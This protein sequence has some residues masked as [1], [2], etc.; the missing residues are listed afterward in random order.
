VLLDPLAAAVVTALVPL[1]YI[2]HHENI[3]RLL[4]GT[5]S[6]IGAKAAATAGH[7]GGPPLGTV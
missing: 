3:A 6:K 7:N 4:D 2:R 5:E 1:V